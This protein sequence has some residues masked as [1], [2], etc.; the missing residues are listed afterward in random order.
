MQL[1][2]A[3]GG[4]PSTGGLGTVIDYTLTYAT[5]QYYSAVATQGLVLVHDH[6]PDG[7]IFETSTANPV[8]ASIQHNSD[9]ST[10]ITWTVGAVANTSGGAITFK[11]TVGNRWEQPAYRLDPIVSGDSMTNTADI[12]GAVQDEVDITRSSWTR[13]RT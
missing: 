12:R 1:T 6:L 4:T 3:K 11:A 10:D 13:R 9:G 7:Q 2:I 8:P 5:S